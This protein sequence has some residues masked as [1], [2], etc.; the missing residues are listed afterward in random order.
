MRLRAT[1][2][3][4]VANLVTFF[5]ILRIEGGREHGAVVG[6]PLFPADIRSIS[7]A[8]PGAFPYTL[9]RQQ[10]G[11]RVVAPFQWEAGPAA[12]HIL[13]QLRFLRSDGGFTVEEAK[14]N[15]SRLGDYGLDAPAAVLTVRGDGGGN[16][17]T[18]KI[19]VTG[20]DARISLLTPNGRI[21]P[22]N[23]KFYETIV[24]QPDTLRSSAVFDI[25][26]FQV[27]GV[28][29]R[30]P[31]ETGNLE[32]RILLKGGSL[33][34]PDSPE[35]ERI[36]R[37]EAPFNGEASLV[38][39]DAAIARLTSLRILRFPQRAAGDDA[40]ARDPFG[41]DA[42]LLRITLEG[43]ARARTLLV[44]ARDPQSSPR[45]P[46]RYAR[47][48]DNAA[49]FT[50]PEAAVVDWREADSRLRE[51][52]FF[53]FHPGQLDEVAVHGQGGGGV[54][55]QRRPSVADDTPAEGVA[56]GAGGRDAGDSRL[57]SGWSVAGLP[58]GNAAAILPADPGVM[59]KLIGELRHVAAI[60]LLSGD[61]PRGMERYCAAFPFDSPTPADL[62]AL[63]FSKPVRRVGLRFRDGS[64]KT[65]LLAA[66]P[67]KGTP[68]HAMLE[69]AGTVY[70]VDGLIA[71]TLSTEPAAYRNRLVARLADGGRV[72]G[73]RITDLK[74]GTVLLD[75]ASAPPD[76]TWEAALAKLPEPDRPHA[77]ALAAQ[78]AELRA[79]NYVPGPF[80]ESIQHGHPYS[81][82]PAGW[83]YR[84]DVS[85]SSPKVKI[86]ETR[87]LYLTERLGGT[88]QIAGSPLHDCVFEVEQPL[89]DALFPLTHL[90]TAGKDVPSVAPPADLPLPGS[91]SAGTAP[92]APER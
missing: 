85:L 53:R 43:D 50:I 61:T 78:V 57:F 33:P 31:A 14:A 45:S 46:A 81:Q 58:G 5:L 55:L 62:A 30:V 54:V 21:L 17:V 92:P 18:V 87:T 91:G 22:S 1:I 35:T 34:I 80:S 19:G 32:R 70:S 39:T 89:L 72:A 47:L 88:L 6:A 66:P 48:D 28:A 37:F 52:E 75:L 59:R 77:A 49:V 79:R 16:P 27:R 76:L 40:A 7:I 64:R 2:L 36:W 20:A 82:V 84:L 74:D 8:G 24:V 38:L 73:L 11:W 15:G 65:L 13:E 83:R 71:E 90:K 3:L 69:G 23:R 29:V 56:A 60:P 25:E 67:A 12:D 26:A 86:M 10:R 9:E 44:G 4:L 41:F 42:P 68:W 51:R 63:G